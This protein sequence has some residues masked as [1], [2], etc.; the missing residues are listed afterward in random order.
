MTQAT[1]AAQRARSRPRPW[2]KRGSP[3]A[4]NGRSKKERLVPVAIVVVFLLT[5]EWLAQSG[6][7]STLFFPAPTKSVA[8][9]YEWGKSGE[10]ASE[11]MVTF[12]RV[13]LGFL[14]GGGIGL[15]TG[16]LLGYSRRLRTMFDPLIAALHPVPKLAVLPIILIVFGIGEESRL[17]LISFSTFFPMF[18]NSMAGVLQINP[19]Y[20]EVAQNYGA[21][22]WQTF[23]K[24]VVP[25]SLPIVLSGARLA[26][27]LSLSITM[28][29]EL[30]FANDGLG[31][32]LWLAWETLRTS[33]LYAT[34]VI[35]A[36]MGIVFNWSLIA[37]KKRLAPWHQEHA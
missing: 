6:R 15:L 33:L 32:V 28:A 22:R 3:S 27:N 14:Y 2:Q 10:L 29:I 35:L 30:R 21:S 19:I 37:A 13:V 4:S 12:S 34:V 24:V 5:W 8:T 20:F 18:I 7:V 17:I 26:L 23:R 11:F 16:L 31:T 36:I 1:P 9:L 25:G